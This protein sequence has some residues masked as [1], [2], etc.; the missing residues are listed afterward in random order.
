MTHLTAAGRPLLT[1]RN[2]AVA[3]TLI[4]AALLLWLVA[5][6]TGQSAQTAPFTAQVHHV[7]N[8]CASPASPPPS[9]CRTR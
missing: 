2:L 1:A 9:G 7:Y 3:A 8:P 4:A 6:R 5:A